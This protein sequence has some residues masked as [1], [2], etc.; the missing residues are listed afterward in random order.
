[1]VRFRMSFVPFRRYR[2]SKGAASV[3][4]RG[5]SLLLQGTGEIAAT[6]LLVDGQWL[7]AET[8]L[9]AVQLFE[10]RLVDTLAMEQDW[11]ADGL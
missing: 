10:L 2:P 1:M 6:A 4:T 11:T 7:A 3:D 9:G 5:F 8:N